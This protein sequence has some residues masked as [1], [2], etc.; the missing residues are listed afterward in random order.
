MDCT[1]AAVCADQNN[2]RNDPDIAA[3]QVSSRRFCWR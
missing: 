3:Q 1:D 2:D